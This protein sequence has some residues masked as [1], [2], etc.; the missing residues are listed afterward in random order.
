MI[1]GS[2]WKSLRTGR[3]SVQAAWV[4]KA[5]DCFKQEERGR[6]QRSG[7]GESRSWLD[8]ERRHEL[9]IRMWAHRGPG[10]AGTRD[11]WTKRGLRTMGTGE[12]T[13]EKGTWAPGC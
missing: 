4:S 2:S 1:S 13:N 11:S 5:A 12:I 10:K 9:G 6:V 3:A 7:R 8:T